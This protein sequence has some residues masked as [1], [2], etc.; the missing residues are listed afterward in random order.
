MNGQIKLPRVLLVGA[1]RMGA[2]L[3]GGWLERGVLDPSQLTILEPA[4]SEEIVALSEKGI[5]L[6]ENVD[7][8]MGDVF[9]ILVLAIKP[10][11]FSE[12]LSALGPL[13][14][15]RP[16]IVSIAAGQ[17]VANIK[18]LLG[19]HIPVA[20]LMP[21]T[22]ALVG[23]GVSVLF[24]SEDVSAAQS[25][26]AKELAAAVGDVH[27]IEDEALMDAVTAVS[28]SGPAYVFLLI[29]AMTDAGKAVGLSEELAQQLSIQTILGSGKLAKVSDQSPATLRENVTSPGGTTEAALKVL[30]EK[31]RFSDLIARAIEE[32]TA[33]G[34]ALSS[35]D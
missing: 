10:Q 14:E 1:G 11:I 30:M 23:E 21:N 8:L 4:P 18:A 27:E 33:R 15:N 34:Q 22:P 24:A 19:D 32:A 9:D 26:L 17:S 2:A 7:A 5:K 31:N 13:V 3:L 6:G 20:R 35:K 25:M 28:G 12:V 29:E 16:L